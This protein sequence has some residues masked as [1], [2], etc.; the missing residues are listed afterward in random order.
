[1]VQ[2]AGPTLA[3]IMGGRRSRT[4][5]MISAVSIPLVGV[6]RV[7]FGNEA[8]IGAQVAAPLAGAL[9]VVVRE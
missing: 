4:L 6:F 1:M 9:D 7:A 2:I 8:R 5:S 3:E